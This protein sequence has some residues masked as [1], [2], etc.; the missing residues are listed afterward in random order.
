MPS[1][2]ADVLLLDTHV[3][4]WLVEGL[5]EQFGRVALR[6]IQDASARG[7]LRVSVISVWEVAMLHSKGRVR[8]L[9]TVDEW[10]DKN[11]RAPGLQLSDLTPQIAVN[12][13]RLSNLRHGDPADRIIIAT[14]QQLP[15]TVVTRDR[16]ML[17]Y[18]RA[19]HF[20]AL[21]AAR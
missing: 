7:W 19:G 11:L 18:A 2:R 6:R 16:A 3:W 13:S 12:S 9:P 15:A 1:E 5:A 20:V 4:I 21:N 17:Q 10:V 14:A 8:C